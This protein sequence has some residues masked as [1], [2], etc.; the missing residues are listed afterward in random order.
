M[1]E[2]EEIQ[3]EKEVV[4]FERD[5]RTKA[6]YKKSFERALENKMKRDNIGWAESYLQLRGAEVR[7]RIRVKKMLDEYEK[8]YAQVWKK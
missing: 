7:R 2:S 3:L 8:D 5:L 4:A 6:T 1:K